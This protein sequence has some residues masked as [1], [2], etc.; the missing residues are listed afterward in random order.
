VPDYRESRFTVV[1]DGERYFE[2]QKLLDQDE[3]WVDRFGK[4]HDIEDMDFEHRTNAYRWVKEQVVKNRCRNVIVR[5]IAMIISNA[6]PY[7]P[8][9]DWL[10]PQER[11]LEHLRDA[12]ELVDD[13]IMGEAVWDKMIDRVLRE[14]PLA[15]ALRDKPFKEAEGLDPSELL[16]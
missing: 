7:D 13:E 16:G 8:E 9:T 12:V 2:W 5:G 4:E 3:V 6:E 14:T 1:H 10:A 11:I 15:R